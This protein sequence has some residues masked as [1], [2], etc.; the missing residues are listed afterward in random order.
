VRGRVTAHALLLPIAALHQERLQRREIG[1]R[2]GSL[3]RC[4]RFACGEGLEMQ[5]AYACKPVV[6]SM[7]PRETA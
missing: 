7:M 5:G 3:S 1:K 2:V 4:A 6:H